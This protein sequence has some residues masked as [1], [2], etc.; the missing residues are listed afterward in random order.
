[1]RP[2]L[3]N[4]FGLVDSPALGEL[5][6]QVDNL[7]P[8]ALDRDDLEHLLAQ[9]DM[10][11]LDATQAIRALAEP[12]VACP[13]CLCD[14][15]VPWPAGATSRS[16][17]RHIAEYAH[18]QARVRRTRQQGAING[19]RVRSPTSAWHGN[20]ADATIQ[21]TARERKPGQQRDVSAPISRQRSSPSAPARRLMHTSM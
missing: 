14:A 19:D 10:S 1:M 5:A 15:G 12:E 6:V 16:C 2:I 20:R 3:A 8:P 17:A 18:Q 7:L 11:D 21:F 9:L 13:G 4:A